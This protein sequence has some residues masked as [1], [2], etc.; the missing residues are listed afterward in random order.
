METVNV[1]ETL[2]W[3]CPRCWRNNTEHGSWKGPGDK[4]KCQNCQEEYEIGTRN[5]VMKEGE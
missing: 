5:C 4:V 2:F 3:E 1:W